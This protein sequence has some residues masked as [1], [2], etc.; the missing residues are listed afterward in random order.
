M[1]P[2]IRLTTRGTIDIFLWKRIVDGSLD[3]VADLG[4]I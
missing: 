4:V 1:N 2:F 3:R